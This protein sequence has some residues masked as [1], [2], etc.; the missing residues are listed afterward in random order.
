MRVSV[1]VGECVYNACGVKTRFN[2]TPCYITTHPR[3]HHHPR[4][5]LDAIPIP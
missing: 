3:I 2:T 4:I 1:G 5:L